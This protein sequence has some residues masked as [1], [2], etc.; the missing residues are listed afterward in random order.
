MVDSSTVIQF[1]ILLL[2]LVLSAFFSSAETALS[3][4]NQVRMRALEEEGDK[5]A[6]RVNRILDRYGKMISTILIGNNIVNIMMSSLTTTLALRINLMVGIATG[7]LTIVIL[8]FGEIVPKTWANSNNEKIALAYSGIIYGLMQILTPVIFV[9]DK[10]SN[11]ILRL[12]HIDPNKK[13]SAM[14]ESE[15]KT[16]VD[17]S[18]ED[19][20][21]ESEEK[22][23]IYNV[24]DFSDAV[25]KDIMIPRI[26][27][28]T[29][30]VEASY[31]DVLQIFR[32][33]MYTRLPVYQDDK[34]NIIGLINIK[35]FILSANQDDFSVRS[36]LREAHYTYEYKKSADLLLEMREITMN[37]AFVLNEYGAT[38]GMITLEDLLEEIVG[39]IRDEYDADEA[40]YIQA[41]DEGT[42]LVEGSMKLDDINDVLGTTLDSE[43]YDSIGGIIIEYLDRLPED[44]EEVELD[45]GIRLKVQGIDQNRICKVVMT[46]PE[47]TS[48]EN[49]EDSREKESEDDSETVE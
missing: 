37:V 4:V 30:N 48:Q 40:E 20:V 47:E 49:S 14:T 23:M 45:C 46:L 3:M 18:H 9:V 6:A 17:V 21:I 19:G 44:G 35:D 24:F 8:L 41:M 27:M 10:L 12:L 22:E 43:D 11:G 33:S 34:D 28:V 15:L 29:V 39:E 31:H 16:Y 25:A 38:V 5:R 42:Y 13:P 7:I 1:V 2:L 32:E 26:N 36:I